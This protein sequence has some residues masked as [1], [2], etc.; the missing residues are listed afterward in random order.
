M[1]NMPRFRGLCAFSLA[2]S[3]L[4]AQATAPPPLVHLYPL[5][6]DS[7]E[8]PVTDLNAGDFK[9]ADQGKSQ[10]IFL[11]RP[12]AARASAAP[13]RNE[14]T[15]RPGGVIPH[16]IAVL[17]DLLN[18]GDSNR[19]NTWHSLAKSIPQ[20][21]SAEQV[22]FYLLNLDGELV[23]VRAIGPQDAG[24]AWLRTFDK[25]LDKAMESANVTR[26]AGLDREDRAKKT[27]HQLEVVS[28]QL[29]T[30]PG[31]RDIVWITN[32]L[33]SI[34]SGAPCGGD[35]V[36]CGLYVA[37]MG[38]TLERDGVAVNP[39]YSS[40]VPQPTTSYDLDQMALLTGGRTYYL[41]DIREVMKEVA[42]NAVNSYEIAYAPS[43]GNWD[44][45]FHRIRIGCDRKGVKL[46]VTERYCALPDTRSAGDRQK[47]T[48][49][50]AYQRPADSAGI[51]LR[52]R[53]SPAAKGIHLDIRM[54]AADLLLREQDGRLA[55]ALTLTLSDLGAGSG[56]G[57]LVR[58]LGDPSISSFNLDLAR[59]QYGAMMAEGIP[60]SLD[61]PVGNAV[62]R[63]RIMV[64][65]RETNEVGSVTFP[66][67]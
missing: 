21:E 11:F 19:L 2:V 18:E 52:V 66:V 40:G 22:Y 59:E 36:E 16:S 6:L 25:E 47:E 54:D 14:Y 34:T 31:R 8:Q 28:N 13:G 55:G 27:Y 24:A 38:V 32:M 48:L 7:K 60:I 1:S 43:A 65:D 26:P 56:A 20:L 10:T 53:V 33:P 39:Y 9:V 50:A 42:R 35:W 5:V 57:L 51:G 61:H 41:Q 30:L 45:K 37:H 46:Q 58:P 62:R 29:A 63:V 49:E 64:M 12:P 15:N 44:N 3:G 17:F 67:R 4:L 23:P